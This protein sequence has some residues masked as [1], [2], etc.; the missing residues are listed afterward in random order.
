M[1]SN[2]R[3]E[4]QCNEGKLFWQNVLRLKRHASSATIKSGLR[5]A[6]VTLLQPLYRQTPFR[7]PFRRFLKAQAIPF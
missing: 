7:P 6:T 4:Q 3:V 2:K 1:T 5:R